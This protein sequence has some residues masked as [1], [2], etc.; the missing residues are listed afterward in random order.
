MTKRVKTRFAPSPTGYLHVGGARTALFS[1]VYARKNNGEF[2]LRVEDTDL[3]RSTPEAVQAILDGMDWLGLH[4]DSAPYYQ[5]EHFDRYQ[6]VID[7]LLAEGKAY[8]CYCSRERLD[9]LRETQMAN[10]QKPRYDGHCRHLDVSEEDISKPHVIRFKNPEEGAVSWVDAVKGEI[11]IAN[12]ELD[13]LIIKRSDGAPTYNFCVVVDDSDMQITHVVRGDDHVNNTPRQINLYH[14]LNAEVPVFAHVPM[15]LGDDGKK[16]SKR[17]GAVSVMQY[18]EEG[19]L[20]Q[21]L[22]NYLIR[23]GWSH[24]DQEVFSMDEI[25]EYF[26]LD[27]I[28]AS[29][30]AFNTEKLNWLNQHYMRHLPTQEVAKELVYHFQAQGLDVNNG[31]AFDALIPVMAEKVKTLKELTEQSTYFY[32]EFEGFDDKAAHKHLVKDAASVLLH[33]RNKAEELND[34]SWQDEFA[35]HHLLKD[36]ASELNLGMGKVG[37]PVRVAVT[38]SGQSPD[39]GLTLKWLGKERVISRLQKAIDFIGE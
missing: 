11:T 14:A 17:H 6:E 3:E 19:Y 23:L 13:D 24:G 4:A 20:P 10:K 27:D 31:P 21:A 9:Q 29:A 36:T 2:V 28:N 12:S 34:E 18:K 8:R 26:E 7:Q 30:S 16:L 5:T 39:I 1:W 25:L 22:I 15:I 35:L 33:V 32:R 37:M 38:G